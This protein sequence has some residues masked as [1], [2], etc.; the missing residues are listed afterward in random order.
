MHLLFLIEVFV[1]ATTS[2]T[3]LMKKRKRERE[4]WI[5]S[6]WLREGTLRPGV[7]VKERAGYVEMTCVDLLG[8]IKGGR[9]RLDL[10][11]A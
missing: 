6:V 9:G 2:A 10:F 5:L 1:V 11:Y 4:S 8:V 7:T 3:A